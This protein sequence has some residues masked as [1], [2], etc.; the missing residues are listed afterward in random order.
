MRLE[1]KK[2]NTP[3][4]AEQF[5]DWSILY[6]QIT[7]EEADLCVKQKLALMSN[8]NKEFLD[9]VKLCYISNSMKEV[10]FKN[11]KVRVYILRA[12]NLTAQDQVVDFKESMA[13][14][15]SYSSANPYLEIKINDCQEKYI[16]NKY[17]QIADYQR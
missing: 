13:G 1:F 17:Q 7:D 4:L 16:S 14:Y 12:I 2:E 5:E 9:T 8:F 3:T 15:T 10:P 11:L 6:R